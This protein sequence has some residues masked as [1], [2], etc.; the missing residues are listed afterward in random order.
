MSR[1][2]R[3]DEDGLIARF[4][5]PLATA[6]GAARLLDDAA[7]YTPPEGHELVLTTDALVSGVHFFAEDPPDAIAR[8]ALRVNLS[9]L[10]AK[11][12]RP[13]GYLVSLA[14]TE[15][16]SEDWLESFTEGLGSDQE[17]FGISLFG[18]DTVRT[19][20]PL[21]IS[22]T[23]FGLTPEG[24][25][26]RRDRAI[27]GQKLYVTGTIGDAALGLKIRLD[28]S[29]ASRWKLSDAEIEHLLDRY[30]L[31]EPR[32]RAAALMANFASASMDVSDGLAGD[33][34]RMCSAS[35]AGA[36]LDAER[37]P[38]SAA[39]AKAV[40]ADPSALSTVLTGGDD[41]EILATIDPDSA[42]AFERAA[43]DRGVRVTEIG[44]IVPGFSTRLRI[45]RRGQ[46]LVL[47]RLAFRHF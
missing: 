7:A 45:E 15:D 32:L 35:D 38:L 4:F 13:V 46:P 9:D 33:L 39:A 41:Y 40:K 2:G 20:G 1:G 43:L 29:L 19:P 11:G 21:W 10:A 8:K 24:Q 31:P 42:D 5:R 30:L 12:A 22:I 34:G 27:S 17:E 23:A 26:P 18:G 6:P 37:V 28:R 36:V 16:W 25:I 47:D 14:L 3:P 44:T